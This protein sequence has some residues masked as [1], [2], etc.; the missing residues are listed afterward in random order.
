MEPAVWI[1]AAITVAAVLLR[2]GRLP[3]AIWAC[4]GAG[5]LIVF[6]LI[7]IST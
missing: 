6:R 7:P 4:S 1:V 5:L 3:E 2:P